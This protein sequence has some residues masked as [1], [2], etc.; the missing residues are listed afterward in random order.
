MFSCAFACLFKILFILMLFVLSEIKKKEKEK[1]KAVGQEGA[2]SLPVYAHVLDLHGSSHLSKASHPWRLYPILS[3]F[4]FLQP[5]N[6][7]SS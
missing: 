6:G 7:R 1:Q 2:C 3:L 5:L 4:Y